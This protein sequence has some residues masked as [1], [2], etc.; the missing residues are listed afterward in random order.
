[1][2]FSL[3]C[4]ALLILSVKARLQVGLLCP[5]ASVDAHITS[6]QA[7][8]F[9]WSGVGQDSLENW[10][11]IRPLNLLYT[12]ECDERIKFQLYSV[13]KEQDLAIVYSGRANPGFYA[14]PAHSFLSE[15]A[16]AFEKL[17]SYANATEICIVEGED[18]SLRYGLE[19][20]G[21]KVSL[22]L[23]V[24]AGMSENSIYL[25]LM[26]QFKPSGI[27]HI[28][29]D[30]NSALSG[31]ILQ[32]LSKG[33][34]MKKDYSVYL[35][36]SAAAF[37]K[38]ANY[39][40]LIILSEPAAFNASS[41][42]EVELNTIRSFSS[43]ACASICPYGKAEIEDAFLRFSATRDL[44]VTNMKSG[45]LVHV[46]VFSQ[47]HLNMI[48]AVTFLGSATS[49]PS[50]DQIE[51]T[52]TLNNG[53]ENPDG[54]KDI[55]NMY[56]HQYAKYGL[57]VANEQQILS[58]FRIKTHE[59]SCGANVINPAFIRKCLTAAK[60]DIGVAFVPPAI[61]PLVMALHDIVNELDIN[62]SIIAPL[63][64][65]PLLSSK[66][67][68]P[69]FVRI[70]TLVKDT[71][72]PIVQFF[73]AFKYNK[74]NVIYSNDAYGLTYYN[75]VKTAFEANAIDIQTAQPID[76]DLALSRNCTKY[77]N[78]TDGIIATGIRPTM[79]LGIVG[80]QSVAI[81]C[82][83]EAGV[84]KEDIVLLYGAPTSNSFLSI[85]DDLVAKRAELVD[86][87]FNLFQASFLGAYGQAVKEASTLE[88]GAVPVPVHSLF[89]DG[90]L[91]I[92]YTL[93][94]MIKR[95]LDFDDKVIFNEQMRKTSIIG[96]TGRISIDENSNDRKD[97]AVDFFNVLIDEDGYREVKILTIDV[98]STNFITV[99]SDP[100]FSDGTSTPPK[101]ALKNFEDCPFPEEDRHEFKDGK[102]LVIIIGSS[103]FTIALICAVV[104]SK[105]FRSFKVSKLI[106]RHEI[107]F[108]DYI[109][110]GGILVEFMQYINF[111]PLFPD[112]NIRGYINYSS[113][114]LSDDYFDNGEVYLRML[115][116][117][118]ILTLCW[119]GM[120][121]VIYKKHYGLYMRA[122]L[123]NLTYI[124]ECLMPILGN[125]CFLPFI[126]V[127][128]DVYICTEG[129]GSSK[130]QLSYTDSFMY[131]NC[132]EYC[133]EGKHLT[134]VVVATVAMLVYQPITIATRPIWQ[135]LQPVLHVKMFPVCL[136]FKSLFQVLIVVIRRG[137]RDDY[138]LSHN[139]LYM[140]CFALY[141]AFSLRREQYN[142]SRVN[143]LHNLCLAMVLWYGAL[144]IIDQYTGFPN[145]WFW[146]GMILIGDGLLIIYSLAKMRLLPNLLYSK[147]N[148]HQSEIFKF[149]F[150]F[151]ATVPEYYTSSRLN[152]LSRDTQI[153]GDRRSFFESS[154]NDT[155]KA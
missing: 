138:T 132:N 43:F 2:V 14:L 60:S 66:K 31:R 68:Y 125:I 10:L 38:T 7:D 77:Q 59:I 47:M 23:K 120:C 91:F 39:T 87:Q 82:L 21:V 96:T 45:Q 16:Q 46:G 18:S 6:M 85:S 137:L 119:L 75:E 114:G 48:E 134:Y 40:G 128:F 97:Q 36:P 37:A 153:L 26:R 3:K 116:T 149:A 49:A 108:Q 133:W 55:T 126:A 27:R 113:L 61:S 90:A 57:A 145:N 121:L 51:I 107:S 122:K 88:F 86:K 95:G 101:Q 34:L 140:L 109:M 148:K 69:N 111:S 67:K 8:I 142:Y 141:L 105:H 104:V 78:F 146:I 73:R 70:V 118:A 92:S 71:V 151:G 56:Y 154:L 110:V 144:A 53:N 112:L 17:L 63:V 9:V 24:V 89:Y 143:I 127:L 50:T 94:R 76:L 65:S 84:R 117:V 5:E 136:V 41:A 12:L 29:V 147:Q 20:L 131:R 129:V 139:I 22:S 52:V 102:I 25:L 80:F 115:Q 58:P 32:S 99:Q 79:V 123:E 130:D 11:A 64:Q 83:Y 72:T 15:Q 152:Y 30:T 54:T 81:D 19:N 93:A 103:F 124:S 44:A 33:K 42:L 4:F 74:V 35:S 1:M 62:T 100:V 98:T 28:L 155:Q 135:E 150:S 13:A 106:E